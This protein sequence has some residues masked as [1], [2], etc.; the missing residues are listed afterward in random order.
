MA[1]DLPWLD[2]GV[3]S[4]LLGAVGAADVAVARTDR[5][6]PMCA[7]WAVATSDRVAA[8]FAG[9]ERA[10]HVVLDALDVVQVDVDRRALRNVNTPDDLTAQ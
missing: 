3:V 7:I 8:L 6:E 4:S 5:V 10:M 9:G 2:V 1:C